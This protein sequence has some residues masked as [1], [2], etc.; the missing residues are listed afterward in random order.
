M[1][2]L[3]PATPADN[4]TIY[5]IAERVW[6]KHY[7]PNIITQDQMD[8]MMEWMYSDASL[9][10]Q[11]TDGDRF[12]MLNYKGDTI[13]YISVSDNNGDLFLNKFY[14]DTE[15]QRLNIGSEALNAALAHFPT[16]KTMRMQVNRKN[17][18]AVNFYFKNGF[19]IE[20]AEDFDIGNNYL[21][22][23][24]VMLRNFIPS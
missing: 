3:I 24:Y 6:S 7:I 2:I 22:E 18:K 20:K 21:M 8:Y 12:F 23:D 9:T 19:T 5:N 13:G 15:Y 17:F 14:I 11:M 4:Q 16:A 1:L 10:K